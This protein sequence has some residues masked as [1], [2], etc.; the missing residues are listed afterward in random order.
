[1]LAGRSLAYLAAS[2]GTNGLAEDEMLDALS[3]DEEHSQGVHCTC[4]AHASRASSPG[5]CLVETVLDL[6]PYLSMRTSEG[7]YVLTFYHRELAVVA[8]ERYLAQDPL[9]RH[10]V[11]VRVFHGLADPDGDGSWNGRPRAFAELPHHLSGARDRDG[12]FRVLTDFT[13]LGKKAMTVGVTESA[14]D[15][16]GSTLY[17]GVLALLDDYQR[18][19]E[20]FPYGDIDTAR[21]EVASNT[22]PSRWARL[23]GGGGFHN[24][25]PRRCSLAAKVAGSVCPRYDRD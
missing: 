6:E 3:R 13:F 19:L 16:S 23:S 1:M 22:R 11:F 15:G 21:G 14:I 2:R 17:T 20:D 12:A 24:L 7:V 10:A 18:T 8:S 5:R 25:R 9:A 4:Q